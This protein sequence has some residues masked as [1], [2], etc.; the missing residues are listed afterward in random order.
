MVM[1]THLI[2]VNS[3]KFILKKDK[4]STG[5]CDFLYTKLTYRQT[6]VRICMCEF[7]FQYK[8]QNV[9]VCRP[10]TV[11]PQALTPPIISCVVWHCWQKHKHTLCT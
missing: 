8:T 10:P 11:Q 4:Q 5:A 3:N 7:S 9:G 2:E 1:A 6:Y